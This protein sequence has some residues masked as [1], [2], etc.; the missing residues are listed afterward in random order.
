MLRRRWHALLVLLVVPPV[1][2]PAAKLKATISDHRAQAVAGVE[3]R[4]VNASSGEELRGLSSEAGSV[5][6][7]VATP[8]TYKLM[9]RKSGYLPLIWSELPVGDTDQSVEP[10]LVTQA[11]L[12]NWS[13]DADAAI[14]KKKLKEAV[15]L[16][17][18]MLL[19]FPQDAGFW[20]NLATTYQLNNDLENSIEA[21]RRAAKYDPA[22]FLALE[23]EIVAIAAY[24]L[25][26]KQLAQREFSKAEKSFSESVKADATYAPAFYGLAL[27][28]A[29]QGKYPQALENVRKAIQL[30]PNDAQ[31]KSIEE[32]L[33]Q[34]MGS[35]Q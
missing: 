20:A 27:S 30:N 8:G 33:K 32:K 23:K 26:K 29:N 24:E 25:G 35:S 4:L 31:Y 21:V 1:D 6:F 10:R 7:E 28:Y 9:I 15:D 3:V 2:L 19:Y 17:K 16:Y 5:E 13:K 34:A 14:K 22:Q 18:Q 12:D 11:V